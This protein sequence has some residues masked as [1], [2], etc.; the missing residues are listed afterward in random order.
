[1]I[2]VLTSAFGLLLALV[3]LFLVRRDQLHISHGLSWSLAI[4]LTALLGFAPGIFDGIGER[5]GVSYRPILGVALAIAALV[6][7]ALLTDIEFSKLRVRHQRLVQKV[8]LLE[9]ELEEHTGRK[10]IDD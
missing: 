2:T 1:M 4:V 5:L 9:S 3:L 6:I 7:K 8:A 10:P